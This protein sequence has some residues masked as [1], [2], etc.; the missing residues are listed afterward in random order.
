MHGRG[1]LKIHFR[2]YLQI[3]GRGHLN[4]HFKIHL[5]IYG[6]IFTDI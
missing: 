4:I 5:Q 1:Y 6:K 2:I 3:H